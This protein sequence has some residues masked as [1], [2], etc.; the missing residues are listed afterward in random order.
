M[1]DSPPPDRPEIIIADPQTPA[2]QSL[3]AASDAELANLYPPQHIFTL[4]PAELAAP[5]VTIWVAQDG[6]TEMP[7]GCIALKA[8]PLGYGEIKRLYVQPAARRKG[9]ATQ[10][11]Q[12]LINHARQ[13]AI[14]TLQ[15]ETGCAQPEA[16]AL[17]QAFGFVR[18]GPFGDYRDDPYSRYYQKSLVGS[19]PEPL[20]CPIC[21]RVQPE[22]EAPELL[23]YHCDWPLEPQLPFSIAQQVWLRQRWRQVEQQ[24]EQQEQL[25]HHLVEQFATQLSDVVRDQGQ[26]SEPPSPKLGATAATVPPAL[27][28][29][30]NYDA[31]QAS[32][33]QGDWLAADQA[34]AALVVAIAGRERQGYLTP[35]DLATLP[36]DCL[37]E[38]DHRW[39]AASDGRFGLAMQ[40]QCHI[41]LSGNRARI[42]QNWPRLANQLGWCR[43]EARNS[44]A[45]FTY[46]QLQFALDAP[47][48]HLPVLG[49]G[50]VWFVGGWDG[51]FSGFTALM[52]RLP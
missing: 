48:G 30:L 22:P 14:Q 26:L 35:E 34:S 25:S 3:L 23:C 18:T 40:K 47:P 52:S 42:A 20:I 21:Q 17:Y 13:Q 38:I 45:W 29:N 10:L 46:D 51:A 50:Q 31:L 39:Q 28:P 19:L 15:L 11:L 5:D 43:L 49:D 41:A 6:P 44:A 12:T 7:L 9:I 8:S 24:I 4:A 16:I 33:D 36:T 1:P 32:L 2:L 37:L 27:I